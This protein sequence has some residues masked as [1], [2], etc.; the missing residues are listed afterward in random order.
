MG[1]VSSMWEGEGDSESDGDTKLVLDSGNKHR[2][3]LTS[4]KMDI[5]E[6]RLLLNSPVT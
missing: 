6:I 5:L 1:E 2:E 4:K 3:Y